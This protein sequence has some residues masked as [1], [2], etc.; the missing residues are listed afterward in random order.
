MDRRF[1]KAKRIIAPALTL[2]IIVSQ[3]MGCAASTQK[4]I[5]KISEENQEAETETA[6]SDSG[7]S[8][9]K[10]GQTGDKKEE[11][12][13]WIELGCL[14]TAPEIRERWELSTGVQQTDSGKE[15][16]FYY[17]N[18]N[19]ESDNN[20]TFKNAIVNNE[21]SVINMC[22]EFDSTEEANEMTQDNIYMKSYFVE[23]VLNY[24]TDLDTED[25]DKA[26]LAG[27]NAY[28]NLLPDSEQGKAD[29][30][31]TLSRKEFM[32][33]VCRADTPKQEV[34]K[35]TEFADAVGESVYN[36]YAQNLKNNSYLTT[37]NGGLD[38]TTYDGE[39]T[40]AEAIYMIVNRYYRDK[41]LQTGDDSNGKVNGYTTVVVQDGNGTK[42]EKTEIQFTDAKLNIEEKEN[43]LDALNTAMKDRDAGMPKYLYA[44]LIVA[45]DYNIIDM[46]EDT[47]WDE[48][49]TKEEALQLLVDTYVCMSRMDNVPTA[50]TEEFVTNEQQED[51]DL[52]AAY[53]EYKKAMAMTDEEREKAYKNEIVQD[54]RVGGTYDELAV[55]INTILQSMP[56]EDLGD[57]DFY[58][59]YDLKIGEDGL[60]Y[61]K[62]VIDGHEVHI[63]EKT[64]TGMIYKGELNDCREDAIYWY[65]STH[66][67]TD[68]T[69]DEIAAY[70]KL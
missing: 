5:K 13:E 6:D 48:L 50:D 45:V 40:R 31:H 42:Y 65:R 51:A 64:D 27:L 7:E 1:M 29:M 58:V 38:A 26:F 35:D 44:A 22:A 56:E 53:D 37:E 15:G 61:L 8:T 39:I 54:G 62:S 24:Y 16:I 63:G 55:I 34:K 2:I 23:P 19:G 46:E 69:D 14:T 28:F 70:F 49:L 66:P 41:L 36:K 11:E 12:L 60:H 17:K 43:T 9:S 57:S 32:T 18:K 21:G 10:E 59:G 3:F 25:I 33:M 20:N 47:R 52:Q 4:E 67:T 30:E 68:M